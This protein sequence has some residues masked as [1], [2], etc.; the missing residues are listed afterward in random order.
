MRHPCIG[1]P[2]C[3]KTFDNG[4]VLRAHLVGCERAQKKIQKEMAVREV[5]YSIKFD[6]NLSGIKTNKYYPG[7]ATLDHSNKFLIKDKYQLTPLVDNQKIQKIKRI[8]QAPDPSLCHTQTQSVSMDF[9][10]YYT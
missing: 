1:F 5:E 10:G 6:Y 7:N 4:Y 9:S 2:L 8:R 3:L